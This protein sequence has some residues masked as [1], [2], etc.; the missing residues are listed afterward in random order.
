MAG[1]TTETAPEAADRPLILTVDDDPSVSRAVARDLRR[2]YGERH[3]IVRAE[4]GRDALE[5][6]REVKLKGGR[7]AVLLADYRMPEMSGIEFLEQAM[8]LFPNARLIHVRRNPV[9]TGFSIFRHEFSK[10]VRFT[11]RLE[12][13]GH[14][15]GEY[16]R[17]MAHWERVAGDRFTTIQYED[18]VRGFDAAAPALVAACGLEWEEACS[19]FW[20]NPRAVST[21]STMQVRRPPTKPST[22][23]RAYADKL[24]PLTATLESMGV[25][26]ET[27]ALRE[28]S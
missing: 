12:D 27:G 23:A 22:P 9:D 26:L 1:V 13:I 28:G 8:D 19:R 17:V 15:Y 5:A 6:L 18:F 10:L 4:S 20:E 24:A 11:S 3:R 21:I 2:K 25:D 16:A 7:V 14:Y